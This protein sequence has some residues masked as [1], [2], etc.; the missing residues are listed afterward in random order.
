VLRR[1]RFVLVF[2]WRALVQTIATRTF[3]FNE[4]TNWG[5]AF[6]FT[7]A[8]KQTVSTIS[9]AVDDAVT[10]A[11]HD[12]SFAAEF[13]D[14]DLG[15]GSPVVQM[16]AVTNATATTQTHENSHTGTATSVTLAESAKESTAATTGLT[17]TSPVSSP[18][19]KESNATVAVTTTS[20]TT[21]SSSPRSSTAAAAAADSRESSRLADLRA[22]NDA[23][24]K[25]L[26]AAEQRQRELEVQLIQAPR[27]GEG[28]DVQAL[29]DEFARRLGSLQTKHAALVCTVVAGLALSLSF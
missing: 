6:R 26:D 24:Q 7:D 14:A 23:L 20:A 9:E 11:T 18:R 16:P 1:S 19:L 28:K 29:R 22:Q 12:D 8:L 2:A 4:M 21:D 5:S 13:A 3:E 17:T 10:P 15:G 25:R 27:G